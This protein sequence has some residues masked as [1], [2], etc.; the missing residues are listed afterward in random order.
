MIMIMNY[1]EL[2]DRILFDLAELYKVVETIQ[3]EP[4]P[5]QEEMRYFRSLTKELNELSEQLNKY[6]T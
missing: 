3:Q 4:S 5:P 6:A 1:N 2:C